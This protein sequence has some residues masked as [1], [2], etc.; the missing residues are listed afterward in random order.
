MTLVG[1]NGES[2]Q[3]VG[4]IQLSIF[5]GGENKLTTF[6]AMDCPSAYN[7]ILARSWIHLLKAVPSTY[8]QVNPFPTK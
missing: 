2:P 4:K 6:L 1:F 7:I 8:H 5:I 3:T